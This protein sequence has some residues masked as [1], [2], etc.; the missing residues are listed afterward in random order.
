MDLKGKRIAVLGLA[1][2]AETDDIRESP[3]IS[4]VAKLLAEGVEIHAHD[5]KAV[6]NFKKLS[7]DIY[8]HDSEFGA[9]NGADD[10]LILT[11]WN[12][13]RNIDLHKVRKAMRGDIIMDARNVLE[14]ESARSLGFTYSGTGR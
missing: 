5:P 10:V 7:P 12:E 14:P 11:E 4:I 1:Y 13:Y 8:Y 3:A 9:V 2:K 6:P